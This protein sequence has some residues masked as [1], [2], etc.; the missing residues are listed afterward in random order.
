VNVQARVAEYIRSNGIMQ[1]F[2]VDKT[3]FSPTKVSMIL[4]SKQVMTADDFVA[5]CNALGKEPNDFV[6]HPEKE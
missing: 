5:F 6:D 2:V 3:G 4:N 1:K